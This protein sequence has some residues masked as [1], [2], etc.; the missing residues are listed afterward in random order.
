MVSS[1][2]ASNENNHDKLFHWP[3]GEFPVHHCRLIGK[4]GY[5]RR[6]LFHIVRL[7]PVKVV[8]V[9]VMGARIVF[10][11]I[12]NELETRQSDRIERQMVRAAGIR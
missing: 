1:Q 7:N 3:P 2:P 9:R 4:S 5:N 11:R 10:D 12:L 6:R 8:L